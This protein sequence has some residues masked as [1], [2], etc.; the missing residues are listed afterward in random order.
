MY[1]TVQSE[2]TYDANLQDASISCVIWNERIIIPVS[3]PPKQAGK[4]IATVLYLYV[5]DTCKVFRNP[6]V[7]GTQR[8]CTRSLGGYKM[9]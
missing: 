4:A 6:S 5:T 1:S 8:I 3:F 7:P 9:N 2:P